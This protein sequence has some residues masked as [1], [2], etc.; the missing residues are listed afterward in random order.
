[1]GRNNN[2]SL[3]GPGVRFEKSQQ[4]SRILERNREIYQCWYQVFIDQIHNLSI[5][6]SKWSV[7]SRNPVNNDIVLFTFNDSGYSKD[8]ITWKLGRVVEASARKVKI[9]FLGRISKSGE[10][11]MHTLERSPRDVSI[12]FSTGEFT[13]NT[14]DHFNHVTDSN[15]Q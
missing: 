1:M 13:I 2:R 7:N 4:F 5:K 12:L 14:Q 8:N 15:N 3:E 9:T 10:S 11:K 6:P